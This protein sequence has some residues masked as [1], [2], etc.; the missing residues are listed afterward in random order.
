MSIK[1]EDYEEFLKEAAPAIRDVLDGTFHEAARIMSPAGLE[2]YMDGA[3][4]LCNLGRG[5]DLVV[6]YLQEMPLVAKEC[7]E[8]I[9]PDVITAAM[10]LSSMTS[11]E[12]ISLLFSSLPSAARNL[13]DAELLRG[14][15]TFIHQ[16]ASTAARG[17]RPMLNHIDE[18]LSKLTLSGL[19][20]WAN[21]GA[22]AYRR[23]F[24]NLTSYFNLESADSKAMLQK[25]RRGVLFIKV[26]RKLNFYLR[27]LW[28][29]D[30]FL[31][32]TGADYTDFRPYIEH[33]ILHMPDAVDDIGPDDNK[34]P[35]LEL[36]RATAAHMAA[37]MCY[38]TSPISAE[39]LSPAQMFFI[40][41]M[42]DARIEFK[43]K[44]DFPGLKKLWISLLK[45]ADEDEHP[46]HPTMLVLE[47]IAL[48]LLDNS[49]TTKDEQLASFVEKFHNEIEDRQ[50]D[51]QFS[52]HMGMDLFNI[53]MARKEV[54]SLRILE[55]IRI[56]YRDDNR[57]VW[58]F[59]EF[60]ANVE[61]EYVPASQ[62]QVRKQVSVIEMANEVDCELAG[63][64]A[65]EI[66][67]CSTN[68]RPYE[69]DLTDEQVSFN[70]MWGKEPIS[71]PFH[72]QEWDYQIQL[73]RPDWATVYERRQPKG[74]P[75]DIKMILDEYKPIAHR[76][77]QIIDLL[78]PEGVQ[79]MR[80]LEDGDEIDIN[81][82]VDAM[83]SIRMGEQPNPRITM[84]NVVKNRDLS[85]V[86]LMDLSESTNEAMAGSDKT[87]LQLTREAATLVST[88]INGIGDPFAL[89]G[90]A[91]DGRHD[92]QYYRFKDFNQHFDDETKSRL[93]GM[94]GGLSTRMGAALRHAG[95]HLLKQQEKRKLILLVTDGEPAD[96][97]ER[98][99]QHLRHDTKKAVEE[100]YGS[101]ILTYCLTL[102]PN[103]DTYVKR[104]FGENNYTIIDN[105]DRLPEKLPTL[106]A[107]LTA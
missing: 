79:R 30:F 52:W 60:D 75:D 19:R 51:N 61:F 99:P 49:V 63:D 31:R 47:H 35:G 85:V 86:V 43:A 58:E 5:S 78:T 69:D 77:K 20:R 98:D 94:K 14:Y 48:M 7:G 84:R 83:I 17:L 59:E 15:L 91:S 10:K 81:A 88:A 18:L 80:G 71:D 93:A 54:P 33:R 101:G 90:F 21:F 41:F 27:A 74:D 82:A 97:D 42:E 72:Y 50:D 104:I 38:S 103:A 73:H 102:D 34:I 67:T 89:H 39:Q 23:D 22:Q 45:I 56:P 55:R 6:T 106:F 8:D 66:W 95:H 62:R 46:E 44:N 40:G 12:V 29:R 96:I 68:M 76:I 105:V 24:E 32:P 107:S 28:G 100:L 25:E 26:Q 70:D 37:H 3:K 65:Q 92:V 87:V 4:A 1:L 36:Y 11:G 57:Y 2:D 13:G 64:D 53:F 16:L 9:I